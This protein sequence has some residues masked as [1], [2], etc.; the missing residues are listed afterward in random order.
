MV[1]T[2]CFYDRPNF[3][4]AI[5]P[6]RPVNLEKVNSEFDDFNSDFH[7]YARNSFQLTFST[8]RNSQGAQFDFILYSCDIYFDEHVGEIDFDIYEYDRL[9]GANFDT[10]N[11]NFNEL[12]PYSRFYRNGD[13]TASLELLYASDK[14]GSLDI[15][16]MRN[17]VK[18]MYGEDR[19]DVY[20]FISLD[21]L[22]SDSDDAYPCFLENEI[23]N[24]EQIFFTSDRGGQFDIYCTSAMKK[25][26][27]VNDTT[28]IV[29]KVAALSSE[30]NDKCPFIFGNTLIFTSD[31]DGG[32]GGYDLWYSVFDG[33]TWSDPVN[34][35]DKINTQY[36]EY[37]PV[38]K[39]DDTGWVYEGD[40][41]EFINNL[42]IFSSN[43]PGGKGGFDLYY[44]GINKNLN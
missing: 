21:Y 10:V 30:S 19:E 26:V 38:I 15:Y 25:G 5:Y 4:V 23:D 43:R 42:M 28:V 33:Q 16:L 22:N 2:A 41:N 35:G 13:D 1:V 27:Y 39:D 24:T 11:T 17:I 6:L 37:R 9:Y 18:P 29:S 44:V 8:N 12:G 36:D 7:P 31:R 3:N 34:F 14:A 20:D 32:L 40:E